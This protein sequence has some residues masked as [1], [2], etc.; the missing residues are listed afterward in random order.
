MSTHDENNVI[1]RDFSDK[2]GELL[3]LFPEGCFILKERFALWIILEVLDG[4][5][6]QRRGASSWRSYGNIGMGSQDVIRVSE[7][8]LD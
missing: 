4:I 5:R 8:G 7:L 2:I 1:F 3:S 6:V